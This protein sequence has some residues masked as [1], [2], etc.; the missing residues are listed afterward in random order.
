MASRAALSATSSVADLLGGLPEISE[1]P[2]IAEE[3]PFNLQVFRA[4]DRGKALLTWLQAEFSRCKDMQVQKRAQWYTN[5]AFIFGDQHISL[6]HDPNTKG[7]KLTKPSGG[8]RAHQRT[9]NRVRSFARTEH[10]KFISRYPSVVAVPATGEDEDQ[11]SAFAAEQVWQ[12]YSSNKQLRRQYARAMWWRVAIGTGFLKAWWDPSKTCDD[13]TKG[14]VCYAS[15]TPF[16]LFVPILRERE[17]EDQPY[18]IEAQIRPL[19][20][21]EQFFEEALAGEKLTPSNSA[22]LGIL[23]DAYL[24]QLRDAP[25]RLDQVLILEHWIKPGSCKQMPEGG[26]VITVEDKIVHYQEGW[27]Y[28]HGK[29][30][31]TKFEHIPTETFYGDSP[32]TDI[33]PMQQEY[34]DLRAQ[35]GLIAKRMGNPQFIIQEGSLDPGK[36]TNEP[37]QQI[38][39]RM[40]FQAPTMV[41]PPALPSYISETMDR[42]LTDIEDLTGQHEVSKGTAPAGVTAGT[43][44]A[45]LKESDD[46]FL[47]P[48][49]HDTE[50]GFENLARQTL[51]LFVQYVD[52]KRRIRTVGA[53]GAFDT[54]MLSG[55]D[56]KDGL[57]IRVE[58]GSSVGTSQAA[59]RAQ[60]LE[61]VDRGLLDAQTALKMMEIG[62]VQRILDITSV[63][64]K[65]AQRENTKMKMLAE[66]DVQQ[67]QDAFAQQ[68]VE[69][70][71]QVPELAGVTPEEI[72]QQAIDMA[73][74]VIPVNDFDM[75]EMHIEVHNRFRMSQEYETLPDAVKQ[76]FQKHVAQH[77]AYLQQLMQEQA[78]MQSPMVG[79]QSDMGG[80]SAAARQG[81]SAPPT[82]PG[83]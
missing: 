16:H 24:N 63:A 34:N 67:H 43:A 38:L 58:E 29:F 56:I 13:G 21:A 71:Q 80:E 37:G 31:Y 1:T 50:E 17:I 78:M 36:M 46:N 55:A 73:P 5:L 20:W 48:Q 33:I 64:E 39:Y 66:A 62:G 69:N 40:G 51:Q 30:P 72:A 59:K 11:R 35:V 15:I 6:V 77:Q 61:M 53:D 76:Q 14:D 32:V 19:E 60:V 18:V 57:D 54:E 4:S 22:Q 49:Y 27:P 2:A 8:R 68:V 75:H 7:L 81:H 82:P 28:D 70:A 52:I 83:A 12:S 41:Q 45:F 3:P 10:S 42:A 47:T 9:I 44:L 65:Q 74:P 79:E 25:N 23:D 26:L